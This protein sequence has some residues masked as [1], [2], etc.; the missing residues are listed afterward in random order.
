MTKTIHPLLPHYLSTKWGEGRGAYFKFR[1]IGGA[2]IRGVGGGG[3]ALIR[4]FTVRAKPKWQNLTHFWKYFL[5]FLKDEGP[6]ARVSFL[7]FLVRVCFTVPGQHIS[8][9]VIR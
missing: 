4:R 1:L 7:M 5:A 2:L 6:P 3:G 8:N 9:Q